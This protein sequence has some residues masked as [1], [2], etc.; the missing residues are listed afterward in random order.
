MKPVT[1]RV[2]AAGVRLAEALDGTKLAVPGAVLELEPPPEEFV[3]ASRP[4]LEF[5]VLPTLGTKVVEHVPEIFGTLGTVKAIKLRPR[6]GRGAHVPET[7]VGV[8]RVGVESCIA[9]LK[10]LV[11]MHPGKN[12]PTILWKIDFLQED[13]IRFDVLS[14]LTRSPEN[15]P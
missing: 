1:F 4:I 2:E 3:V 7:R 6:G 5:V 14:T 9:F 8:A 12:A 10:N 13:C 11:T 15:A